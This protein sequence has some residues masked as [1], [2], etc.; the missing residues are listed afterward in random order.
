MLV[1][2]ASPYWDDD[3]GVRMHREAWTAQVAEQYIYHGYSV[4]APIQHSLAICD[5]GRGL[6]Q[7]SDAETWLRLD[8]DILPRCDMLVV[9]R[10]AGYELSDGIN[11]E[12]RKATLWDIPKQW[13]TY[14]QVMAGELFAEN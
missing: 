5:C 11:Q 10:L 1:Y 9:L 6:I 12:I 8:L 3:I 4:F 7:E 14:E 2:L 13:R